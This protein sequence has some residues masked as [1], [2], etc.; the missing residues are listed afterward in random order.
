MTSDNKEAAAQ[1]DKRAAFDAQIADLVRAYGRACHRSVSA[2]EMNNA[3]DAVVTAIQARATAPQAAD[4]GAALFGAVTKWVDTHHIPFEEQNGLF[5]AIREIVASSAPKKTYAAIMAEELSSG[6]PQATD[7][8]DEQATKLTDAQSRAIDAVCVELTSRQILNLGSH[9]ETLRYLQW[10]SR[11]AVPQAKLTDEQRE[12]LK[13]A[14]DCI[15]EAVTYEQD[16]FD[17]PPQPATQWDY[18][19]E[20]LA[21]ALRAELNAHPT[22]QAGADADE[23]SL[24]AQYEDACIQA[25]KNSEDAARLDWL[26]EECCDLRSVSVPTGG[27]DAD[28]NWIVIQHHMA[29]PHEREIGR[30]FSD[31]PR[32][33]IDAARTGGKA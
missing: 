14:A 10:D 17:M 9:I 3:F 27:D 33:A 15:S 21:Y 6:A 20:Q 30:G 31:D 23:P 13:A 5:K 24:R 1:P 12:L 11:A 28:V 22:E 26:Q 25:N 19:A 32:A 7:K 2:T 16:G 29:A 18:N 8:G 4:V